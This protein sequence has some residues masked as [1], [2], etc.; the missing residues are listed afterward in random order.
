MFAIFGGRKE[1]RK[2]SNKNLR[3]RVILLVVLLML[4]MGIVNTKR[5]LVMPNLEDLSII[6]QTSSGG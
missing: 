5:K 3:Y 2:R 6:L 1:K 4:T